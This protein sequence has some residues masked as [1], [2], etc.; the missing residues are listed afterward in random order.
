MSTRIFDM[1]NMFFGLKSVFERMLSTVLYS[2][3]KK[4]EMVIH[5]RLTLS[6]KSHGLLLPEH[7]VDS[8]VVDR[9]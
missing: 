7:V 9:I 2:L 3:S 5:L 1:K 6:K 4:I 8:A